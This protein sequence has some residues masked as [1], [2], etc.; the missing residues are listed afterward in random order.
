MSDGDDEKLERDRQAFIA[1]HN[2]AVD[3]YQ[4][5]LAKFTACT[6]GNRDEI[7]A[8]RES[9]RLDARLLNTGPFLYRLVKGR[10]NWYD[11]IFRAE[12][13]NAERNGEALRAEQERK[14]QE[15]LAKEIQQMQNNDT[16]GMF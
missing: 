16:F 10:P 13:A 11:Q 5:F 9:L 7:Q 15:E 12:A 8:V 3:L 6:P 14:R 2:E 4:D 1:K